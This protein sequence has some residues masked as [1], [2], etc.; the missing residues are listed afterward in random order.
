M[1]SIIVGAALATV[2]G[3]GYG[4]QSLF[5]GRST[6]SNAAER[7]ALSWLLGC[8]VISMLI[9][10]F[11]FLVKGAVLPGLV[12]M[13]AVSLALMGWRRGVSSPALLQLTAVEWILAFFIAAEIAVVF[14]L[15]CVHTLGWDGLLNWEIKAR[16][17]FFNGG[18]LPATYLQDAGRRF[19]HQEYPLCIPFTELWLYFWLGD[20]DQ[21]WA[22]MIFPIFYA[23]GVILLASSVARLTR[24][25]FLGLIA[26]LLLFF[27]PQVSVNGGSAI[28]GYAD[29][30]MSICYLAA[31]VFLLRSIQDNDC[32][33]AYAACL[34]L[35]PWMKREGM[36][37]WL[38]A[39][40]C[41]ALVILRTRKPRSQLVM[42]LPGLLVIGAWQFYLRGMHIPVSTE[43]V[44]INVHTLRS[45][46]HRAGPITLAVAAEFRNFRNWSLLW[47]LVALGCASL[48]RHIRQLPSVIL[49]IAL[50]APVV[51]YPAAYIFS[52]W[53]DYLIHLQLSLGRLLMH[54][55]PLGLTV[56]ALA[57]AARL[58]Q[59]S[60]RRAIV[61]TCA[62]SISERT[63]AVEFA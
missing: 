56:A 33:R 40:A 19:S 52:N 48:L 13:A 11:G 26:A 58:P 17:A 61:P 39:A 47:P 21:F 63:P 30:P 45:H 15:S 51:L 50:G 24:R 35:L 7:I 1:N 59:P 32:F 16:Y 54:V 23:A 43:F 20:P 12:L 37:L 57:A 28:V 22:K 44:P 25:N 46:L 60:S 31:I 3:C 6:S 8:G 18:V 29:F 34:A 5:A 10:V 14:Y 2:F 55:A 41:G 36:V 9:W 38:I 4:A 42:L 53:P 49:L 62:A 27:I